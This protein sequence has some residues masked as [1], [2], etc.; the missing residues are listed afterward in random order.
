MLILPLDASRNKK[1][2][3]Y[4]N[5][6]LSL[7]RKGKILFIQ[8]LRASRGW[9]FMANLLALMGVSF[10][11]ANKENGKR[12]FAREQ[13]LE[14]SHIS[15]SFTIFSI[16]I[17]YFSLLLIDVEEK[18]KINYWLKMGSFAAERRW[19]V[20]PVSNRRTQR[21]DKFGLIP[22]VGR[23]ATS[24]PLPVLPFGQPSFVSLSPSWYWG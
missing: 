11:R 10:S 23:G 9:F 3:F 22:P 1:Y 15:A 4:I 7:F 5:N 24:N 14:V 8:L 21:K 12:E 16:N 19:L 20:A 6:Q 17:I 2:F 18:R 13:R